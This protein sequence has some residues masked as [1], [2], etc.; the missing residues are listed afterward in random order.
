MVV[1]KD[2]NRLHAAYFLRLK[3]FFNYFDLHPIQQETKMCM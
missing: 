3:N 1:K 2:I